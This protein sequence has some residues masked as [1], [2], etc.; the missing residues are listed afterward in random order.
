MDKVVY[1][2]NKILILKGK[3]YCLNL[4]IRG[5]VKWKGII[6]KDYIL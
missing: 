5:L 4:V 1:L 3:N 6:L 2:C